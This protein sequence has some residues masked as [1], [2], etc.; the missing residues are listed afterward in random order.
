MSN[1]A[2][3][4]YDLY[5]I[6]NGV[7]INCFFLDSNT[8]ECVV[9]TQLKSSTL[10]NIESSHKLN[11]SGDTAHGCIE[12][13]N[14]EDYLIGVISGKSMEQVDVWSRGMIKV[15]IPSNYV[16]IITF[17]ALGCTIAVCIPISGKNPMFRI[18]VFKLV[19]S[20]CQINL[21]CNVYKG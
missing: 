2:S 20:W 3:I 19:E 16:L 13:V 7:C 1:S 11:R 14:L 4:Q 12:G 8:S 21:A 15:D 10:M 9:V 6:S 18:S 5:P 17:I